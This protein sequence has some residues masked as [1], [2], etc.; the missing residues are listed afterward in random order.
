MPYVTQVLPYVPQVLPIIG[1]ALNGA[2]VYG[3]LRCRYGAGQGIRSSLSSAT[4]SF[5]RE[6]V[7]KNVSALSRSGERWWRSR[8]DRVAVD[9]VGVWRSRGERHGWV[10]GAFGLDKRRDSVTSWIAKDGTGGLVMPKVECCNA[11]RRVCCMASPD[12]NVILRWR[13][14]VDALAK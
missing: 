6:Q 8:G 2:N 3:Y 7:M 11:P 1:I 9:C 12:R 10:L 5:M 14:K 13:V 4:S